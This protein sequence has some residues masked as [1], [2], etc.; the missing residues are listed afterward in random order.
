MHHASKKQTQIHSLMQ[1]NSIAF[2]LWRSSACRPQAADVWTV[3]FS[4]ALSLHSDQP[5][6][7]CR[8]QHC[9]AVCVERECVSMWLHFVV[10]AC[11]RS[12]ATA[13]CTLCSAPRCSGGVPSRS[14]IY[15]LFSAS[16]THAHTV[17]APQM[18]TH[19]VTAVCQR[20]G[21]RLRSLADHSVRPA[22]D[23]CLTAHAAITPIQPPQQPWRQR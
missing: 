4:A 23:S 15:A 19:T 16:A 13:H 2:F 18:D 12:A 21:L 14:P 7:P 11:H 3:P 10:D 6:R 9:S 5:V 17:V 20:L 1:M 8:G 22:A